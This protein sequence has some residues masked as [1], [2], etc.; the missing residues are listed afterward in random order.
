MQSNSRFAHRSR[1]VRALAAAVLALALAGC[2][3]SQSRKEE[4]DSK[5]AAIYAQCD[6]QRRTGKYATHLAAVD[7]AV[8]TVAGAYQQAAYPFTDLVYISVQARRIGANKVDTGETTEAEYQHDLAEL[9]T[10]LAAEDAR[11]RKAMSHGGNPQPVPVDTLVEGRSAFAPA[12]TAAAV[13]PPP[14]PTAT[15]TGCIPLSGLRSCK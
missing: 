10:R 12:P 8:P 14:P 5:A 2:F 7:C 13:P 6:Q 11:R 4:A 15:A 1:A 9:D 3:I